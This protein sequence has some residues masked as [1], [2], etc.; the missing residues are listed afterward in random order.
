MKRLFLNLLFGK[1]PKGGYSLVG[2]EFEEF[3]P[4]NQEKF[5]ETLEIKVTNSIRG[6]NNK[7]K[8]FDPEVIFPKEVLNFIKNEISENGFYS[9]SKGYYQPYH[10]FLWGRSSKFYIDLEYRNNYDS[11]REVTLEYEVKKK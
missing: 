5:E 4:Y 8:E 9:L 10:P 1:F 6:K 7:K 3:W 11:V 2:D